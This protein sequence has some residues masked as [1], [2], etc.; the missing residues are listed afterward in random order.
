MKGYIRPLIHRILG[1]DFHAPQVH[2]YLKP[3]TYEAPVLQVP[4]DG[5]R[6]LM[7]RH[8]ECKVHRDDMHVSLQHF[9]IVG[10]HVAGWHLE[11]LRFCLCLLELVW[12][13]LNLLGLA[14]ACLGL[15]WFAQDLLVF[16]LA[17]LGL[18]GLAWACLNLLGHLMAA[19]SLPDRVHG[20][21]FGSLGFSFS[22]DYSSTSTRP[23]AW[24]CF[25]W[26]GLAWACLNLLGNA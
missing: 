18:L 11:C 15:P 22:C 9:A 2:A 19:P 4:S 3:L 8:P 21:A 14:W 26:L 20:F 17:C 12:D 24:I 1:L 25:G 23:S 5:R 10:D 6:L 7:G 13:C 16:A